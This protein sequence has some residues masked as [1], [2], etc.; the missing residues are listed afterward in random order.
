M[1]R[2]IGI[3]GASGFIGR[4]LVDKCLRNGCRVVGIDNLLTSTA[5]GMI[6]HPKYSFVN[7]DVRNYEGLREVFAECTEL[8]HLAAAVGVRNINDNPTE[9]IDINLNGTE[10]MIRIAEDTG[11]S[12]FVA[13]SSE[14]YGKGVRIPFTEGDDLLIGDTTIPRWSYALSKALDEQLALD[15]HRK[16]GTRVVI[17][18]F[19]NT[20]GP[21]QSGA[22]GMVIPRF[23]DAALLGENL[24][25]HGDGEQTRCFGN[26][27][28]VVE[29]IVELMRTEGAF[30]E[31]INIGSRHEISINNLAMK[32]IE[33]T[34]STSS[35]QH[36]PYDEV[37]G[38]NFED[39]SRRVPSVEKLV[40]ILGRGLE[41][42]IDEV[43]DDYLFSLTR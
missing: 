24:Q 5:E 43:I 39:L 30:G 19:F 22:Y 34:N 20:V 28:E 37:F 27:K 4:H 21:G 40:S 23:I 29:V 38:A 32:I 6:E 42:S 15:S 9:G 17:G 2:V 41:S 10:T 26:V 33:K 1:S 12:L 11:S 7:L 18:R 13:S 8:F 3:T 31:V 14:V 35:I 36:V 25:V 16:K